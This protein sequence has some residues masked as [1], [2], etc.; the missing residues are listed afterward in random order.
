MS[1]EI[2]LV[3]DSLKWFFPFPN[4]RV[5]F[6]IRILAKVEQEKVFVHSANK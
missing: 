1:P 2:G 3:I 6:S 5:E 4:K